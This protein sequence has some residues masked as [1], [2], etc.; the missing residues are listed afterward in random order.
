M[1]LVDHYLRSVRSCLPAAQRDDII[2]ELSE[3]LRAQIE[4]RKDQLGGPLNESEVETIL[5]QHGHP[6]VVASRYRQDQ[7]SVSFGRQIIGPV[8]F[9]FYIRVLSFNLGLTSIVILIVLTALIASGKSI[10]LLNTLPTFL[11][12]FLIQ[13]AVI[14]VIFGFADRHWTKFPDRW[15]PR[16]LKH[17]WHPVF[18]MQATPEE[19]RI[20]AR[21]NRFDC[22]I[23]SLG[24]HHRLASRGAALAIYDPWARRGLYQ[25][26]ADLASIVLADRSTGAGGNGAGWH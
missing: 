20:S 6:L 13:F 24:R 4:D 11:Y 16:G 26:S 15:D 7:R 21:D 3:N 17:S 19:E 2:S 8:L 22:S 5:K 10:S 9:P 23:C 12:Q 1:E 18:G 14:T 25:A